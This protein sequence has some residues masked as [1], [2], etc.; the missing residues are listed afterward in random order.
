MGN[1]EKVRMLD[2]QQ[3][4]DERGHLV[5]VEG[6]WISLLRSGVPFTYMDRGVTWCGGSMPTAG[7]SLS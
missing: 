6:G 7:R 1:M 4:G 2:F 5:V 3:R